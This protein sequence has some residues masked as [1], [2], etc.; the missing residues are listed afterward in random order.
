MKKNLV[1]PLRISLTEL[2]KLHLCDPNVVDGWN[3]THLLT[4]EVC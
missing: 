1:L 3:V 2:N 4:T